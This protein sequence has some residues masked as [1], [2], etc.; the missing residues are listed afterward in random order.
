[1][2]KKHAYPTKTCPKCSEPI[3]A[4]LTKHE[5]C[6][7]VQGG[8]ERRTKRSKPGHP[9]IARTASNNNVISVADIQAV[10]AVVDKLGAVKVR[11]L[12]E[13]LE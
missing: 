10:K 6:G 7:W 9:K 12:A 3:H 5:A 8:P 2:P 4:R 13:V 11:Q 1:M